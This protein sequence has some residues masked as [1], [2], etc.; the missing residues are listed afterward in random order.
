MT[1]TTM[2]GSDVSKSEIKTAVAEGRAVLR[3]SHG[4]WRNVASLIICADVETAQLE[5]SVD[6]VGECWSMADE[7]WS[8]IP[9][10]TE[11]IRAAGPGLS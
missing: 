3:W 6:T 1:Y 5:A 11:A 4:N 9:S 7:C 10:V 2:S 8:S